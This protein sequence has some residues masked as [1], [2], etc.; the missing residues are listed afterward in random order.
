M[1]ALRALALLLLAAAAAPAQESPSVLLEEDWAVLA[2]KGAPCGYTY[3]ARYSRAGADGAK[4]VETVSKFRLSLKRLGAPTEMST[5]SRHVETADGRPLRFTSRRSTSASPTV[6]EGVVEGGRLKLKVL[7]GGK[8]STSEKDWDP[9][10]LLSEGARLFGVAKGL[11]KGT[12]YSYKLYNADQDQVDTVSI[13]IGDREEIELGG[14]KLA[15]VR[16]TQ[17]SALQPAMKITAW[18]DERFAT[19]RT[20]M[21]MMGLVFRIDRCT[22]EEAL[23]EQ[24]GEMPDVFFGSMPRADVVLPR[25]REIQSLTLTMDRPGGGWETWTAPESTVEVLKREGRAVTIRVKA[26]P[27]SAPAAYPV[28][29]GPELQPFLKPSSAIQ[30]D[31]PAIVAKAKELVAGEKDALGA[32]R[33]L[34]GFVYAHIK[35]KSMDVAQASA[36][37]VFKEQKGDCSEHAVLLAAMFRAAGIPAR[38]CSGYLY[39]RGQF[40]GHAWASAWIGAWTDFDATIGAE[41][42]DAARVKLSES[43]ADETGSPS[44]G[45]KGAGYMHGGMKISIHEYAIGGTA[46][47]VAPAAQVEGEVFRA[48]ALGLTMKRPE[49]WTWAAPRDLHLAALEKGK[50]RIEVSYADLTYDYAAL[51]TAKLAI[52]LDLLNGD[53]EKIGGLEAVVTDSQA[54]VRLSRGEALLFSFHGDGARAAFDAM[55]AS[56]EAKK[57]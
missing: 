14:K 5:D 23:K 7:S 56:I 1:R 31:D 54:L 13:E 20:E 38:V 9:D 16:T 37:E 30:C 52:K 8:E 47:K 24:S 33:K 12:S 18:I 43:Q 51:T 21:D 34:A 45:M 15:V 48:P 25:P 2:I 53:E 42:A 17:R 11:A 6:T 10:A 44:E 32:A 57:E 55:K 3:N 29:A 22:K 27:P 50:A 36:L 46:V 19:Q 40:G 35:K 28:A 49:G 4:L 39:V 26:G 41:P